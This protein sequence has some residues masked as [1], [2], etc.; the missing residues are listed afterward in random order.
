MAGWLVDSHALLWALAEPERL[1]DSAR[2]VL[3]NPAAPVWVS[4]AS[5]WEIAIKKQTGKLASPDDLPQIAVDAGFLL[6]AIQPR[7]AWAVQ[8]LPLDKHR[9]PFDRMLVAQAKTDGLPII[10]ADKA[11]D[12]YEI[13]RLW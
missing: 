3:Q 6:L 8:H 2:E 4:A 11:L 12:E 10:S 5:L 9:D 7:H 13:A 1:S